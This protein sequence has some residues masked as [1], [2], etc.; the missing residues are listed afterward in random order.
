MNNNR[1]INESKKKKRK[2]EKAVIMSQQQ[3]QQQHQQKQTN[4]TYPRTI[5]LD[6]RKLPSATL[7]AYIDHHNVNNLLPGGSGNNGVLTPGEIAVGCAKHFEGMEV[8][9]DLIIGGFFNK[10]EG[11]FW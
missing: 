7:Y 1:I 9:E 5:S 11:N 10:L 8:D 6:F 3:Q 4:R 2:K